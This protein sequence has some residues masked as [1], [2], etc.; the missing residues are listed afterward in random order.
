MRIWYDTE[1]HEIGPTQPIRLISIGMVAEDGREYYAIDIG[2]SWW[3]I[4]KNEWLRKN[5]L[6]QLPGE[7]KSFG[8][9]GGTFDPDESTGLYKKRSVIATEV[10]AFC[11]AGLKEGEQAELWAYYAD[12]DHVVLAQLFGTM[13]D[14]PTHMPMYTRD[15][16][17]AVDM[18]Q[19]E[20]PKQEDTEHH[21]L[22]DARWVREAFK[23]VEQRLLYADQFWIDL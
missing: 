12:Y 3:A 22:A 23:A 7:I 11:K 14:L 2:T 4:Y 21:A 13:I 8:N 20:L 19:V 16:K 15:I 1:F 17:H 5:V 9:G 6:T 10:A 18:F